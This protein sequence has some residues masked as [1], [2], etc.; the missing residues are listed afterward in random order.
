M[1]TNTTK[2]HTLEP[3]LYSVEKASAF[4]Q[5][6]H[7]LYI[8]GV[9]ELLDKLPQGN[10]VGGTIPYFLAKG[11]GKQSMES[12][13][14]HDFGSYAKNTSFA[15]YGPGE[16]HQASEAGYSH[17]FNFLILPAGKEVHLKYALDASD[18]PSLYNT[19]LFGVVAGVALNEI[20]K[21]ESKT[22]LGTT[23]QSFTDK[24]V[25]LHVELPENF[26]PRLE[27]IN[28]FEA[29]KKGPVLEVEQTGFTF[30]EVL[31][32]GKKT[33]LA[34][35]LKEHTI[36]I[37]PPLVADYAG[38]QVNV[39]FQSNDPESGV[40]SFYAPLFEGEKYYFS[41]P[42]E[43]YAKSFRSR[44]PESMEEGELV[45]CCNC[46]LNYLYGGLEGVDIGF[47]GPITFGEVAYSLVNQTFTYLIIDQV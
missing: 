28:V 10:W 46:I 38:A 32:N 23:G 7:Q 29:D 19:P 8:A 43:D 42:I 18:W 30:S 22:Y 2:I 47:V 17:G 31:I 39:S 16:I 36:G 5:D 40:T 27:I 20:G 6:G 12:V 41:K 21:K 14:V 11:G 15:S 25:C 3:G 35:Y 44:L 26:S 1:T 4:I 13:Y 34:N 45:F 37:E 33:N 24:A 9:E